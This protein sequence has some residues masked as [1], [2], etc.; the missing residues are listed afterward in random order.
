MRPSHAK[1]IST[2]R[3]LIDPGAVQRGDELLIICPN[4][5]HDDRTRGSCHL[6]IAKQVWYCFACNTGGTVR[7]ALRMLGREDVQLP[8]VVPHIP[9]PE[10]PQFNINP[11]V[12]SA[13][14]YHADPWIEAGFTEEI[15]AAH[16]IGYDIHHHRITIPLFDGVGNLIGI[17]GRAT[18]PAQEPRYK[19]YKRELGDF[20]P[21]DYAP[22]IHNHLWRLN[23]IPDE[24]SELIIC[25]GFKAALWVAQCGFENVVAICG[26]SMTD[27]QAD[28]V[29]ARNVDALLML[30]NDQAGRNGTSTSAIKLSRRGVR[31]RYVEYQAPAPDD[32]SPQELS[33]A[34]SAVQ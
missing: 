34:L 11:I 27:A 5:D 16:Q 20:V 29:K 32:L 12:L 30:D 31:V 24:Y 8:T 18:L 1:V 9:E 22:K 19:V 3:Q 28:L 14:E 6:N 15:L 10:P 17:S 23:M 26:A 25:E 4:P 2:V 33:A 21:Y 7:S 13:Y